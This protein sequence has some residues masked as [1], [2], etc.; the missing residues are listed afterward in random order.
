MRSVARQT[1]LLFFV[2]GLT[3]LAD[4]GYH[5]FLG[6]TLSPAD[7]AAAQTINATLLVV[8]TACGV[9]QPVLARLTA[10]E[11]T[12]PSVQAGAF[13]AYFRGSA[14][15]GAGL[16]ALLW[17]LRERIAGWLNV[18]T[19][20]VA[21]VIVMP[22]L[23]LL[24]P[25]AAGVLQGQERLAAFGL[26]RSSFAFTRLVAA[27]LL[28]GAG[29][30][31][32]GAVA[33]QPIAGLVALLIGLMLLGSEIWRPAPP[34]GMLAAGLRLSAAAFVA[35]SAFMLMQSIDLVWVNRS[36]PPP[37]AAEYAA[38][39]LLRR[40]AALAPGAVAV[41]FFPLAA[42]SISR[43]QP[44]DRLLFQA[45]SAVGLA[46]LAVTA[47]FAV[48]GQE[49]VGFFFGGAYPDAAGL[50][51][52]MG[53]GMIGLSMTA[54]WMNLF[55][56][57]R[58]W[59]FVGLLVVAAIAQ[60]AALKSRAASPVDAAQIFCIAGWCAAVGGLLLYLFW[61]RPGLVTMRQRE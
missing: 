17:L 18:P 7:F 3:N 60:A 6:R 14:W 13:Q 41:A 27:G 48:F 57:D 50:L 1:L 39:V 46:V 10:D 31:L 5:V 22:L 38:A 54:L 49:I 52:W 4:Y 45:M 15:V 24:R 26:T 53:L 16:A 58:P 61:L 30:G 34:P 23:S 8:V 59:F 51:G 35:Y 12:P 42:A 47:L 29:R 36:L 19:P 20:A 43:G 33:S 32:T 2:D 25:L 40:M 28:V 37:V 21:L 44:P 9:M 55:L 11:R 56:A